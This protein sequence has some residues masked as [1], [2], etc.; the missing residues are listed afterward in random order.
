[1]QKKLQIDENQSLAKRKDPEPGGFKLRL[2]RNDQPAMRPRAGNP[3]RA[4][5]VEEKQ[6]Q[7]IRKHNDG[8]G[9]RRVAR[10]RPATRAAAR[11]QAIEKAMGMGDSMKFVNDIPGAFPGD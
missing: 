11:A 3:L 9:K 7:P 1:M 10:S 2:S 5:P 4:I 8:V 6:L